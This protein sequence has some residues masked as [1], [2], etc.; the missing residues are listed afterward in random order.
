MLTTLRHLARNVI[1]ESRLVCPECGGAVVLAEGTYWCDGKLVP[2]PY[3]C[4]DHT[5]SCGFS[6]TTLQPLRPVPP[7]A[8]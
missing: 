3:D 6:S 4:V 2:L 7:E 8:R 1:R 5:S